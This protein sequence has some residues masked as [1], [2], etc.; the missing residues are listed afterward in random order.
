LLLVSGKKSLVPRGR[1]MVM[2][3]S[4]VFQQ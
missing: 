1:L 2:V 3:S 4:P